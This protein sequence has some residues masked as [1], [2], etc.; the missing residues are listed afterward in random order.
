MDNSAFSVEPRR[1]VDLR[2]YVLY[3]GINFLKLAGVVVVIL[4]RADLWGNFY[5]GTNHVFCSVLPQNN[6]LD[7]QK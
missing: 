6:W 3:K 4:W 2:I 5:N 1:W 7:T